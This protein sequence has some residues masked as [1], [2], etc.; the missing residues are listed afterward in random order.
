VVEMQSPDR[1]LRERLYSRHLR[2]LGV[3]PTVSIV[4]YLSGRTVMSVREIIGMA[5]RIVA[6]AEVAGVP[7][8]LDFI[9]A[10]LEPDEV[11]ARGRKLSMTPVSLPAVTGTSDSSDAF[12]FDREKMV[13]VWPDPAARLIEDMR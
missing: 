3:E 7:V 9:R 1:A 8:T 6:S 4:A 2:A 12:F 11:R 10:E 13:W 5:N